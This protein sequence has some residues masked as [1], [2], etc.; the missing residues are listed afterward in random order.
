M[1]RLLTLSLLAVAA[2]SGCQNGRDLNLLG[3]STRPQFDEGIRTV[4]VPILKSTAFE[5]TP[6]RDFE[7]DIT[8]AVIREIESRTRMKV[9]SNRDQADTEL[10]GTLV[11]IRKA[12]VNVNQQALIREAEVTVTMQVIWR[13]LRDGRILSNPR[14]PAGTDTP[15]PFDPSVT[16]PD[17]VAIRQVPVPAQII[18]VGR[19]LP[20]LGESNATANLF[21]ANQLAKQVVNMMESSW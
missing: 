14:R 19:I 16:L 4:Y 7:V 21:I 12:A 17:S 13:D 11:S 6:N 5:T 9:V 1:R 8:K 18:A 20:E 2:L 15:V 10:I 3:Y